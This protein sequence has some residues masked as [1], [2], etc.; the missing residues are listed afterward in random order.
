MIQVDQRIERM[1]QN[2]GYIKTKDLSCGARYEKGEN[3]VVVSGYMLLVRSGGIWR[4]FPFEYA[5]KMGMYM[6]EKLTRII[7]KGNEG[8]ED[9]TGYE[10]GYGRRCR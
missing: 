6:L 7:P 10:L 1:I 8:L 5:L 4:P 2:G 3:M 9:K